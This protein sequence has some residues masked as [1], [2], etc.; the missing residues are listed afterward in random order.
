MTEEVNLL[1]S[2]LSLNSKG[3]Q[4]EDWDRSLLLPEPSTQQSVTTG[5]PRNS[6]TFPGN[7]NTTPSRIRTAAVTGSR[8]GG[9]RDKR[10]LSELLRVHAEKGTDVNF[11]QEEALRVADVLGQWV[12]NRNFPLPTRSPRSSHTRPHSIRVS[13]V[14]SCR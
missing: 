6:V 5:T 2:S 4:T 1:R 13:I 9:T 11:S 12:S 10:S 7:D 8:S 14:S 3:P